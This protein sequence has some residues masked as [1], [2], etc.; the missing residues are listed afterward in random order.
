[1]EH[2][3]VTGGAGFIGSHFTRRILAADDVASVTVLDA[4]TYAGHLANLG[5]A[6]LNPKLQFVQGRVEEAALVDRLMEGRT[7]VVHFAAESHVDRSLA[8]AGCFLATNVI[9]THTV[10]DAALRHG[11]RKVVHVSTDE[12]YG[13]IR[14]GCAAEDAP[15]RPTVPYAASKAASDLVALSF[16]RT[17]GLPVCVTR[18][19]NNF[20]PHQHPEKVIPLFICRLING[21]R[22]H[23]HGDGEHVRNWLHVEDHCRALELVLRHGTPGEVYNIAGEQELT[24]KELTALILAACGADWDA[25]DYIPDRRANDC[26][27][28]MDGAKIRRLGYRP[29]RSVEDGLPETVAWYRGH[30]DRWAP[31]LRACPP[32]P[33]RPALTAAGA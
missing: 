13:P 5:D 1:M 31:L 2:L 26:R 30:P 19:A 9:G 11:V 6:F 10:M 24:T 17:H 20:G 15:L 8:D 28:A 4:L 3:L 16:H 7:A 27:Y 18:A 23:L 14:Q 29:T 33:A 12:V 25:V 22:V 32:A 21:E